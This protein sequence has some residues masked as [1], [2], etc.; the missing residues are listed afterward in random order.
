MD[1]SEERDDPLP[2]LKHGAEWC[3][4]AAVSVGGGSGFAALYVIFGGCG[5]M[6]LRV[7]RVQR[8]DRCVL[9]VNPFAR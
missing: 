2:L 8:S 7:A 5:R 1:A 3:F 9:T 4:G 6:G